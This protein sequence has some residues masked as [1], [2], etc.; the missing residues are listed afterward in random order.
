MDADE[1]FIQMPRVPWVAT[2]MSQLL[3]ERLAKL[4]TPEADRFM[5]HGDTAF[6]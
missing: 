4:E 2:S 6:R 1:Q 5:A 3:R